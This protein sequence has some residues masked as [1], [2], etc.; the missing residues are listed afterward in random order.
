MFVGNDVSKHFSRT[1]DSFAV[2]LHADLLEIVVALEMKHLHS[3][4]KNLLEVLESRLTP[5][6][7]P[8][9][10]FNTLLRGTLNDIL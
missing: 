9:Q 8:I 4:F 3:K 6:G 1:H 7:F 5:L 10:N 2:V